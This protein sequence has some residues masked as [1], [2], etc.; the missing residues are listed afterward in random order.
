MNLTESI[1]YIIKKLKP[2]YSEQ[3]GRSVARLMLEHLEYDLSPVAML[4]NPFLSEKQL[5]QLELWIRELLKNKP[6]QYILGYTWFMDKKIYVNEHCLIPRQETE[7]LVIEILKETDRTLKLNI[8]DI[9]TGSGCI[10]VS[11]AGE[12]KLARV[13]ASDISSE[14]INMAERNSVL[15]KSNIR[16]IPDNILSPDVSKYPSFDVIVSNPPYVR[17]QEKEQ[18]LPHVLNYEP[19]IALFVPNDDPL[20]FYKAI[21]TFSNNKLNKKGR[22]YFEINEMFGEEMK[23][24]LLQNGFDNICLLQD[25]HG[26]N[27]IIKAQK[28]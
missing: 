17:M 16:F 4:E 10:A 9:G 15:Y 22:L 20:V 21:I 2:V 8:L 13:Y 23:V 6:I 3:E 19:S 1:R 18:M 27:R 11:L 7:E 12:L 24:I 26:K 25:I 14:A 5:L 28:K